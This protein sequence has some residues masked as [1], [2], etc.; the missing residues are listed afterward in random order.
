ML[1]VEPVSR[2]TTRRPC[3]EEDGGAGDDGGIHVCLF[4]SSS[5]KA[6]QIDGL[7][8]LVELQHLGKLAGPLHRNVIFR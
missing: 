8:A 6:L 7:Q 2:V 5:S 1:I 4:V 3:E